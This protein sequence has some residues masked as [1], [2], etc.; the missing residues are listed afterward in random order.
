MAMQQTQSNLAKK[1]G[2]RLAQ[3]AAEHKD[4]P[5]DTGDLK[6]PPGIRFGIAK[7][8]SIGWYVREK[9][10]AGRKAGDD[11]CRASA[12][13]VYPH[14][15]PN[16]ERV[17][18]KSTTLWIDMCDTPAVGQRE[19][20]TWQQNFGDFVNLLKLLTNGAVV[21]TIPPGSDPTGEKTQAWYLAA[22][23]TLTDPARPPIYIT[24]STRLYVNKVTK[25]E[26][27]IETWTGLATADQ[28]AQFIAGHN[29]AGA[30]AQ[31][32]SSRPPANGH[33]D[34]G[35]DGL[36]ILPPGEGAEIDSADAG[37]QG[38][39]ME[40]LV[41]TAMSDPKGKTDEGKAACARL[42]E[43]AMANGWSK[44]EVDDADS[45]G[46]VGEMAA[47][48]KEETPEDKAPAVNSKW[49]FVK[50]AMDGSKM[51]DRKGKEYPAIEVVVQSVNVEN[52]TCT[53]K[54]DGKVLLDALKK[55]VQVKWGWLE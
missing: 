13:V 36:P 39:D 40:L 29:P 52:K 1:F 26:S 46:N 33:N 3:A 41:A 43:L 22:M 23:K 45:W 4:K 35:P 28:I 31:G 8:Q 38:D 30:V 17:K 50:R 27:T 54:A 11:Y 7:L 44:E 32:T 9:D 6:L 47:N 14:Q 5:I 16:G 53:V 55:P 34:Q 10:E 42:E 12:Q 18:G 15:G 19:A 2:G 48:R 51:T 37:D 21:C 25:K 49:Q 20:R 24:F